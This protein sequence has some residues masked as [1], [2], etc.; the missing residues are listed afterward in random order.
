[1][2]VCVQCGK[3]FNHDHDFCTACG[4]TLKLDNTTTGANTGA[5]NSAPAKTFLMRNWAV[6]A[7]IIGYALSWVGD[8]AI[9]GTTIAVGA[10][11]MGWGKDKNGYACSSAVA[12]V[13]ASAVGILSIAE[14][15]IYG[16]F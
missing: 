15:F 13:I 8:M 9:I 2:K 4:S 3:N 5:V 7:A 1:M 6:V 14:L 12:R 16:V 10:A 11:V